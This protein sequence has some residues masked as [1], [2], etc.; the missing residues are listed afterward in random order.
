M[1]LKPSKCRSFSITSGKAS[2]VP[3]KIGEHN[4][5]SIKDEDQKFL[6]KLLFYSGKSDNTFNH[7]K[8]TFE[9]SLDNIEKSLVRN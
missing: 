6:G 3:F 1:K 2:V 8:N 9:E 5:P 7:L 4:I